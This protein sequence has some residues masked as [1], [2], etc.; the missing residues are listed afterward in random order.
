M[1]STENPFESSKNSPQISV[2]IPC[3]NIDKFL[4]KCIESILIQTFEDFE[5]ILIDD[6]SNDSTFGI[7]EEYQK[8]DS[9]VKVF[10]H[11]NKGVSYTRNRGIAL[12][13]GECIMFIDGDDYIKADFIEKLLTDYDQG[14]WP[15]CGMINVRNN[16]PQENEKYCRLLKLYPHGKIDRN[17]F[18]DLLEYETYSSPCCRLYSKLILVQN[19]ILFD[20]NIS[21]QEDLVFNLDYSKYLNKAVIINYYGYYYIE[22]QNSSTSRFHY[23]FDHVEV[24]FKR[25]QKMVLTKK[26]ELV[27]KEFVFQSILRNISNI[28]HPNSPKF[29]N[30]KLNELKVVFNSESFKYINDF[31]YQSKINV[32][33]KCLLKLKNRYLI[34]NYFKMLH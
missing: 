31:I 3:Y 23:T 20:E 13:E 4:S 10:S 8:R 29:K 5:L 32:G 22:H 34:Y 6:G 9:R 18:L 12:A 30:Q 26:D 17:N 11:Q 1:S 25:L 15:I 28:F 33:L 16:Q 27:V 2:I 19:N 24:L 14:T 7:C 21:Y